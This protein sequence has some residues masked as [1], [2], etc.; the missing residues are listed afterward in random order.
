[1]NGRNAD[2]PVIDLTSFP[3]GYGAQKFLIK[4][5][6]WN[7]NEYNMECTGITAD[8]SVQETLREMPTIH[9]GHIYNI[10]APRVEFKLSLTGD[11]ESMIQIGDDNRSPEKI[12]E[13]I[14]KCLRR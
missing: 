12:V 3:G 6:A 11:V 2:I 7:G 13:D 8:V 1:M 5:K 14:Y 10:A 9:D 4:L